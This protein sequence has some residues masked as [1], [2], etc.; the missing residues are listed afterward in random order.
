MPTPAAKFPRALP[1]AAFAVACAAALAC[2]AAAARA[3]VSV[4]DLAANTWAGART[5]MAGGEMEFGSPAALALLGLGLLF[6]LRHATEVDH[7]VA[8]SSIVSEHRQL[9]KAVLVGGLWGAGHTA[10]LVAVGAVVLALRVAIPAGVANWLEFLVAQMII[11]LGANT[12]VRALR[13]RGAA[14]AHRHRHGGG[15]AHAHLHFHEGAGHGGRDAHAHAPARV[16]M[17]PLVVG[18]VH[19]LAG[20]ATLTLLVLARVSSAP[21]GLLFLLVFGLGSVAGMLLMSGLVGLPFVLTSRRL[22]AGAY[23]L[24]TAAG[25]A[26]V[27]FGLWY[28]YRVGSTLL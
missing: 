1:A 2:L 7:V 28:A 23:A 25:A 6:G 13:R 18:A 12:L 8:V 4:T 11:L 19:G 14:H 10:A 5:I 24:Q 21:L 20:S 17:K 26:S 27:C 15:P 16:G 22:G 3:G 9:R